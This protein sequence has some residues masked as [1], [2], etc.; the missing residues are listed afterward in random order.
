M[1]LLCY[2]TPTL[3]NVTLSDV[4]I[5][6]CYAASMIYDTL[7]IRTIYCLAKVHQERDMLLYIRHRVIIF[8]HA[9]VLLADHISKSAIAG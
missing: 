1:K 5:V 9:K 7:Y 6:L 3:N 2:E 4:Y 8:C